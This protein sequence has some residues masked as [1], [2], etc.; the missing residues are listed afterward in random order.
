MIQTIRTFV[1]KSPKTIGYILISISILA[2]TYVAYIN[3]PTEFDDAYMFL[4]YAKQIIAGHGHSW[5][6]GEGQV[7]GSTSL[8][9]LIVVTL[10]RWLLYFASDTFVLFLSSALPSLAIV[11]VFGYTASRIVQHP[12]FHRQIVLCIGI[13][14]A[15][16]GCSEHFYYHFNTGMDTMLCFL[17]HSVLISYVLLRWELEWKWKESFIIALLTYAVFLTRPEHILPAGI[18]VT[19]TIFFFQKE[20]K[21]Q[22]VG[23]YISAMLLLLLVDSGIK[24][25]IF[26]DVLP[27]AFYSKRSGFYIDYNEEYWPQKHFIHFFF[28][29]VSFGLST[30][31]VYFKKTDF[32]K[33]I[34]FLLPVG[35]LIL[36]LLTVVQIMGY[37]SRYYHPAGAYILFFALTVLPASFRLSKIRLTV[38]VLST[39]ALSANSIYVKINRD[40]IQNFKHKIEKTP[41]Y[42]PKLDLEY[43]TVPDSS[44]NRNHRWWLHTMTD[45][46]SLLREIPEHIIIS[47]SEYGIIGAD[48]P[49]LTIVDPL[50]LHNPEI[51]KN[52]FSYEALVRRKPSLIWLSHSDYRT[53]FRR[54]LSNPNFWKE[55]DYYPTVFEFGMA[56]RK[57]EHNELVT[58]VVD[59]YHRRFYNNRPISTLKATP[60]PEVLA[61]KLIAK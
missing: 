5:N 18:F 41:R 8:T 58:K 29:S 9:H 17:M 23:S 14:A 45:M 49:R 37:R 48:F 26:S 27:L 43:C 46:D 61:G 59:K 30:L 2:Y 55:Y 13:S 6:I 44:L 1:Q 12:L 11:A 22:I 38:F 42:F 50:G 57:D 16:F 51:A 24:Y 32:K 52:G 7:Y 60:H 3:F 34:V 36:Y 39:L 15:L 35:L 25:L 20:R 54:T 56:I 53:I 19:L 47:A 21:F 4:R 28:L 10:L 40:I 33:A 31:L